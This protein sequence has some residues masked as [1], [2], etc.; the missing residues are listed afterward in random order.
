LTKKQINVKLANMEKKRMAFIG[1]E[2]KSIMAKKGITAY[3]LGKDL[4]IDQ[5][6]LSRVLR[7]QI[8]PGYEFV[9][10]VMSYLGFE[11]RFV[12]TKPKQKGG[13]KKST[14]HR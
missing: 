4:G 10:K 8:N 7:N 6:Y 1:S 2:I 11:I 3:R 13:E 5:A 9:R 14:F 12:K